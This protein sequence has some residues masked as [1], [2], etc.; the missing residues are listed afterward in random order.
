[1]PLLDAGR[2]RRRGVQPWTP[3]ASV[4]P[5]QAPLTG[6]PQCGVRRRALARGAT[7]LD[8]MFAVLALTA[9][10]QGFARW[11]AAGGMSSAELASTPNV[12][13]MALPARGAALSRPPAAGDAWLALG[14]P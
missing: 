14:Q 3:P 2:S 4:P 11:Q 13:M 12:T 9:G 10:A 7:L 5:R 8:V 6:R 1:M